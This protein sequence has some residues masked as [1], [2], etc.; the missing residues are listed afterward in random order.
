MMLI[1]IHDTS[2][3]GKHKHT[4]CKRIIN[5]SIKLT[6]FLFT[7][8]CCSNRTF[9]TFMLNLLQALYAMA[10]HILEFSRTL[11]GTQCVIQQQSSPTPSCTV[12]PQAIHF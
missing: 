11:P 7:L 12:V 4:P 9:Y 1:L 8:D 10:E 3:L 6:R 5:Y 2:G